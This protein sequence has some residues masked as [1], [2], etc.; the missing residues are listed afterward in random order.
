MATQ[1]I[2]KTVLDTVALPREKRYT[3]FDS[4]VPGFGLRVFPSGERSWIFEYRPYPGGTGTPKK[5]VTIGNAGRHGGKEFPD[6]TPDEA[7]K[8]AD[9]LRV[10]VKTGG[11]PMAAKAAEKAAPTVA[12]IKRDF[13]AKW[14][15]AKRGAGTAED[16]DDILDRFVIPKLGKR[17]ARDVTSRDISALHQ[18]MSATPYQAN[19]MLSVV[20]SMYSWATGKEGPLDAMPN[21]AAGIERFEEEERG[22][23]LSTDEL[24]RLGTAV[25]LAETTGVPWDLKPDAKAKHRRKDQAAQTTIIGEHAAAAIR[26]LIFTG[27]RLREILKLRWDQ[28]DAERGL[29]LLPKHKTSRTA[30]AKVI[31]LNAPA[32]AV[33]SGLTR[34]G[35]YVIA[36]DTAGQPDE[37]PRPDIKRPWQM[38]R[39]AAGLEDLRLH[40]LR[41]NFGGFGAGGGYGLPIIGSLLGHSPKNP[42]TTARYSHLATD[43]LRSAA[44]AIGADIAARM[45]ELDTDSN[46][47]VRLPSGKRAG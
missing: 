4:A 35:I 46:N 11:D 9:D 29:L 15:R 16:Y 43:P 30:G 19:K 6:F 3:L 23:V 12:D 28:F 37:K 36:G 24:Q 7:R 42:K 14:V 10:L 2:T 8:R 26:L 44:N 17:K 1:K 13:M 20:S 22:R 47:V 25:R 18:A 40:D 21:P 5:R 45:G 33:L 39:R 31:V 27:A 41:H 32:L 34:V 38:V